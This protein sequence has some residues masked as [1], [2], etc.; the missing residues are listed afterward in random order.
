MKRHI[1]FNVLLSAILGA[2]IWALSPTITGQAEPWDAESAYYFVALFFA[3]ALAAVPGKRPVWAIY[4]GIILG[5]LLFILLF[6]PVGPLLSIGLVYMAVYSLLSLLA[7]VIIRRVHS[8]S[9]KIR[10]SD[11]SNS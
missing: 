2:L 9:R 1:V 7:V 8:Y 4:I 6:L 3:G 5:Q 10:K 11:E